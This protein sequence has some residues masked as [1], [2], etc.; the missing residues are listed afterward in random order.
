[1]KLTWR[2]KT[3]HPVCSKLNS[4][5][6][7]ITVFPKFCMSYATTNI[8]VSLDSHK[9]RDGGIG[10]GLRSCHTSP[11]G[12]EHSDFRLATGVVGKADISKNW[13]PR[14]AGIQKVLVENNDMVGN[15]I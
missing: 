10:K 15:E 9:I 13:K 2:T 8:V 1:M 6:I 14:R 4:I 11:S 3:L 12:T 5:R 7:A